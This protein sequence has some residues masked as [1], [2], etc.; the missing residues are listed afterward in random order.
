MGAP[1]KPA[2]PVEKLIR[3]AVLGPVS[4]RG[5]EPRDAR[6]LTDKQGGGK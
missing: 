3:R 6:E 5:V 4:G 2:G 1:K